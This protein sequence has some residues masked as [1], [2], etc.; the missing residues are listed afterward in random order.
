MKRCNRVAKR[1][2]SEILDNFFRNWKETLL[3]LLQLFSLQVAISKIHE[4][5]NLSSIWLTN[6]YYKI[7]PITA[8]T[9]FHPLDKPRSNRHISPRIPEQN[10]PLKEEKILQEERRLPSSRQPSEYVTGTIINYA[11]FVAHR[12][13]ITVIS[14]CFNIV[15]I[16]FSRREKKETREEEKGGKNTENSENTKGHVSIIAGVLAE[17]SLFWKSLMDSSLWTIFQQLWDAVGGGHLHVKER[18]E[19]KML[20]VF[21]WRGSRPVFTPGIKFLQHLLK[22][23]S[24]TAEEVNEIERR[25]G[26]D[27]WICWNGL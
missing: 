24:S 1:S 2:N 21:S 20:R 3:F 6:L 16:F 12:A 11:D 27:K 18:R 7:L 14:T 9:P 13:R 19:G 5:N 4:E 17:T 23:F 15:R 10:Y 8:T 22:R 26:E 25:S